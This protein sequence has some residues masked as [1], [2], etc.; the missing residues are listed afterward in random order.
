VGRHVADDKDATDGEGEGFAGVALAVV[1]KVALVRIG[2]CGA[3]VVF[4]G[5]AV[6]VVIGIAGV[7]LAV[8]V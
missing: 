7:P 3:V 1:V 6:I 8:T 2:N 4:I 5:N